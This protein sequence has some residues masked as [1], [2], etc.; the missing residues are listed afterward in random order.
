MEGGPQ[1]VV[2]VLYWDSE[3]SSGHPSSLSTPHSPQASLPSSRIGGVHP[4]G[5]SLLSTQVTLQAK[6]LL[7]S[8]LPRLLP[9]PDPLVKCSGG[10]GKG[11][12][13]THERKRAVGRSLFPT[14]P[15]RV[16]SI[17]S[18]CLG[19]LAGVTVKNRPAFNQFYYSFKFLYR[20]CTPLSPAAY[21][22]VT[23]W[24]S[25]FRQ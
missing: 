13:G 19:Q 22:V 5:P 12:Q 24:D 18:H 9:F 14:S 25:P 20:P 23:G 6:M 8:E 1:V 17:L 3:S 15:K 4:G 16:K 21:L 7:F 2:A 11:S 10:R